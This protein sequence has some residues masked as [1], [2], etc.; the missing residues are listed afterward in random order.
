L[1]WGFRTLELPYLTALIEPSNVRSIRVAERLGM[2]PARHELLFDR[3]MI[4][5]SI[6]RERRAPADAAARLTGQVP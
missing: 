2:A 5:Y 6:S 4:V 3:D 1:Q